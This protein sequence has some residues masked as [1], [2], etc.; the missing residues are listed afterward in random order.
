MKV[1][2]D[3][4]SKFTGPSRAAGLLLAKPVSLGLGGSFALE[5]SQMASSLSLIRVLCSTLAISS[6]LLEIEKNK[7][8]M[9]ISRILQ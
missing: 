9:K 7:Q 1:K 4:R 8:A 6:F 3:H 5:N 2:S